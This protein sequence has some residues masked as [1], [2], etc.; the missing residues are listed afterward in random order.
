[1]LKILIYRKNVA[2]HARIEDA[3]A[4]VVSHVIVNHVM[5]LAPRNVNVAITV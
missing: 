5:S 2:G 3:N 4:N 1:M